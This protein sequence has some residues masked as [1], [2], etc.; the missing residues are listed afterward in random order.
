MKSDMVSRLQR[1]IAPPDTWSRLIP[2][3]ITMLYLL[4][5]MP[6]QGSSW[7]SVL[8]TLNTS[9]CF[10]NVTLKTFFFAVCRNAYVLYDVFIH[11]LYDVFIHYAFRHKTRVRITRWSALG[12][13]NVLWVWRRLQNCDGYFGLFLLLMSDGSC[14]LPFLPSYLMYW[15]RV[16][17]F[18]LC[19]STD[20][21]N[22]HVL[23]YHVTLSIYFHVWR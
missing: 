10:H 3:F 8:F 14:P 11:V 12:V 15:T 22:Y 2:D 17:H 4:R 5:P 1:M 23:Y 18:V 13:I 9:R 7:F 19:W 21:S 20:C 16:M 6:F